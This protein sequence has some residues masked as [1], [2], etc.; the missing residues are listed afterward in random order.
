MMTKMVQ[1]VGLCVLHAHK[2]DDPII[3]IFFTNVFPISVL[4]MVQCLAILSTVGHSK[5]LINLII[6]IYQSIISYNRKVLYVTREYSS[7]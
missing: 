7:Q 2:N 5:Y 6:C 1:S 4:Y 3:C